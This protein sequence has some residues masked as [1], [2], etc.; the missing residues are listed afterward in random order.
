MGVGLKKKKEL[1]FFELQR[2]EILQEEI[3]LEIHNILVTLALG[4]L[5]DRLCEAAKCD[6]R[7]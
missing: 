6:R 4:V 3:F 5:H 7:R 2:I 1:F